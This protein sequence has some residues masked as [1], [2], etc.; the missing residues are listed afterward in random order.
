MGSGL[1]IRWPLLTTFCIGFCLALTSHFQRCPMT[2]PLHTHTAVST[3]STHRH[4]PVYRKEKGRVAAAVPG[5]MPTTHPPALGHGLPCAPNTTLYSHAQ[6][7]SEVVTS[8]P[9]CW[10]RVPGATHGPFQK[11]VSPYSLGCP[12]SSVG[13]TE[14]GRPW[15]PR[16]GLA[17]FSIPSLAPAW[18]PAWGRA[19]ECASC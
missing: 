3:M 16:L 5:S 19:A 10:P 9:H 14:R 17:C 11:L 1:Y 18:S 2:T 15:G 6:R 4:G 13:Q 8:Y 7:F 12:K